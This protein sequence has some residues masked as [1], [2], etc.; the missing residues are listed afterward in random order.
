MGVGRALFEEVIHDPVTGVMLNGNLLDYKIATIGDCGPIGTHLVETAQGYG[1]YGIVGIGEDVATVIPAMLAPAVY[2]AL[3][4]WIYEFPIT[5]DR[6]L[7][8][9][10]KI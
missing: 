6:V 9:L 8:A 3:G 7:K 2:N 10:G 1:P 5:P 4:I